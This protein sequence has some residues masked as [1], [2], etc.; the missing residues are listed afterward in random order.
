MN[1]ILYLFRFF[2]LQNFGI[3]EP[4]IDNKETAN[5][6]SLLKFFAI[7]SITLLNYIFFF[8]LSLVL[9]VYIERDN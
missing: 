5:N 4:I 1:A 8:L 3:I 7:V 2:S 9:N 6:M